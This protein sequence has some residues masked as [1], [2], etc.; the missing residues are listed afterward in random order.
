M[1]LLAVDCALDACQVAVSVDGA[2]RIKSEAMRKGHAERVALLAEEAMA[3]AG[4]AFAQV[5]R[6]AVTVGPGSFAGVRVGLSFARGLAVA[7]SRPCLGVSTLEVFA[8][9]DGDDG[10]RAG[11]M[12]APD[13]VFLALYKDAAPL[14]A[15]ARMPIDAAQAI[16]EGFDALTVTGPVAALFEGAGRTIVVRDTPPMEALAR[17]A[18]QSAPNDRPPDPLYLRPPYATL[19]E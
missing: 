15:P 19:P 9:A 17:L 2:L 14:R 18:L 3:E 12:H 5:D 8:R 7:L 6:I 10:V 11:V 4:V 1:I 16:L 13:G